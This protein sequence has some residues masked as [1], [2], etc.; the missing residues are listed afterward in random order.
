M[1][2]K[3]ANLNALLTAD[4]EAQAFFTGLPQYVREHIAER[5][6]EVNS[7]DSLKSHADNATKGDG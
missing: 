6:N 2:D 7:F 4:Q 1:P 5:G 3:H